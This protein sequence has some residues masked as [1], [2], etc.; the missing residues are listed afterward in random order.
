[1]IDANGTADAGRPW[2]APRAFGVMVGDVVI[3]GER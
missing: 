3:R 1:M 2:G